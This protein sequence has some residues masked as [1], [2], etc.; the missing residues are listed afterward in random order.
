M[1]TLIHSFIKKK[2]NNKNRYIL[3]IDNGAPYFS[4]DA[5]LKGE[6]SYKGNIEKQYLDL[7][8]FFNKIEKIFN[9]KIIVIPHPKYKSYSAKI[10]SLNPFFNN[11]KVDNHYNALP[12]LSSNCLFFIQKHS[13]AIAFP[14]FFNKPVL[15][16]YSS[17]HGYQREEWHVLFY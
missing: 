12:R 8:N 9:A 5:H 3:Y 16:I 4:G 6:P 11:R 13:T 1:I 14:I 7:N 17:I 2:K 15:F 10:K